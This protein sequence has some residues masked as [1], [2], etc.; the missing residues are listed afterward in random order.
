MDTKNKTIKYIY[1]TPTFDQHV[2]KL[3]YFQVTLDDFLK[4]LWVSS[5][6]VALR[7]TDEG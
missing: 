6:T 2:W 4:I 3:P 5:N 1:R 7:V